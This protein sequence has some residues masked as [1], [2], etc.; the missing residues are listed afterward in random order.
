MGGWYPV[1]KIRVLKNIQTNLNL[2]HDDKI[3]VRKLGW[4]FKSNKQ[5]TELMKLLAQSGIVID[6]RDKGPQDLFLLM[7]NK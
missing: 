2:R 4:R 5:D 6:V 1:V 3:L 7:K